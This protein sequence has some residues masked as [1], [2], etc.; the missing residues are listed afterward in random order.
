M[1][2][3]CCF[4]QIII[5]YSTNIFSFYQLQHLKIKLNIFA[6]FNVISLYLLYEMDDR[7]ML[8]SN[9]RAISADDGNVT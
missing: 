3:V 8:G 5:Y 1:S 7:A 6:F 4:R 2:T 9:L